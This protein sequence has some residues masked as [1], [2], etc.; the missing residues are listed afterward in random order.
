MNN[1]C[2]KSETQAKDQLDK[3]VKVGLLRELYRQ[4]HITQ[5]QFERLMQL[6]RA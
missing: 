1:S 6:Q 5:V 2:R 3:L 4:H